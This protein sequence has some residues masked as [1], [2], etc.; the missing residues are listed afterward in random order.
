MFFK[1]VPREGRDDDDDCDDEIIKPKAEYFKRFI[2]RV[3]A[4]VEYGRRILQ[5]LLHLHFN[6]KKI[7]MK[8]SMALILTMTTILMLLMMLTKCVGSKSGRRRG[9]G[10]VVLCWTSLTK[11]GATALLLYSQ[12]GEEDD[13]DDDHGNDEGEDD[14]GDKDGGGGGGG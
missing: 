10:G 7:R 11:T 4:T 12:P 6:Q 9:W 1:A 13:D 5:G 3:A 2:R 8:I 14:D